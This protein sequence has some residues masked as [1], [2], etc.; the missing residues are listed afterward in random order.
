MI[1][2]AK[3][4]ALPPHH[5]VSS[6]SSVSSL[7][8]SRLQH[9][10]A[11][12]HCYQLTILST[13]I[14]LSLFLPVTL[15]FSP[16][17]QFLFLNPWNRV[18]PNLSFIYNVEFGHS[19]QTFLSCVFKGFLCRI[20]KIVHWAAVCFTVQWQCFWTYSVHSSLLP[21]R[22]LSLDPKEI[23]TIR[24]LCS[25]KWD[26]PELNWTKLGHLQQR[27]TEQSCFKR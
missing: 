20:L 14:F 1:Y 15:Y 22:G 9:W 8:T 26:Q 3:V 16:P 13:T 2:Q 24:S 10:H 4:K 7:H 23:N 19:A 25:A 21:T 27:F 5:P 18:G 6:S 11:R 12:P 17:F